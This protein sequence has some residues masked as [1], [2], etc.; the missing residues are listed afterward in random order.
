MDQE[1]L[2]IFLTIVN[3]NS[4][5]KAAEQLYI[6]QSSISKRLQQLEREIGV[7]LILRK[8]GTRGIELTPAGI[9]FLPVA[10]QIINLCQQATEL[11][12]DSN[13]ISLSIASVDSLNASF[14][15]PIYRELL[16][17]NPSI[18]LSVTTNLSM[19]I[20]RF[21]EQHICDYGFVTIKLPRPNVVAEPFVRQ[22]FKLL[23]FSR[24]NISF[25]EKIS[26]KELDPCKE[27]FQPW[28]SVFREW[29]DRQFPGSKYY[30]RFD[31][32]NMLPEIMTKEDLWSIVPDTVASLLSNNPFYHIVELKNPP[33]YRICYKIK[34]LSPK[35]E[36]QEG[37]KIFETILSKVIDPNKLGP[38]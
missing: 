23:Y 29:H 27:V 6:S 17:M 16:E 34:N 36:S 31:T 10:E 4:V 14:L 38:S 32:T 35:K 7:P 25:N 15:A 28:G 24:S 13:R 22:N 26:T 19:Q 8:K 12:K 37:I 33:P 9:S 5:S 2:L 1:T 11:K 21:V 3:M 20:Y 18:K 30:V